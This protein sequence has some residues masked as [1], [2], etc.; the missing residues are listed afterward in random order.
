MNVLSAVATDAAIAVEVK[1][2]AAGSVY[3]V[4]ATLPAGYH[5]PAGKDVHLLI[6]TDM[7]DKPVIRIPVSVSAEPPPVLDPW[8]ARPRAM[9][10]RPAPAVTLKTA[11][12]CEIRLGDA[13][14][15]PEKAT[16]ADGP[17]APAVQSPQPPASGLSLQRD[18][19]GQSP[20]RP[21]SGPTRQAPRDRL[22]AVMFWTGR[23]GHCVR[24]LPVFQR[25]AESYADR[26]VEFVT[27]CA[28]DRNAAQVADA[29]GQRGLRLPV[30]LDP[31][32]TAARRYAIRAFP[33]VCLIGKDG[34]IESVHGRRPT[35][36][37]KDGLENL[38]GDLRSQLD[39]LLALD[40]PGGRTPLTEPGGPASPASQGPAGKARGRASR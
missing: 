1:E 2:H 25:V 15:T 18:S 11:D 33:F 3:V 35:Y 21:G 26:A 6:T 13:A 23:C 37:D 19:V 20:R 9:V 40:T 16:G 14:S 24:Q 7:T 30:G 22:T 31:D 12:G 34:R 39:R 28:G 32:Y 27:V 29:A 36:D 8:M 4:T 10:G 38:E 17:S 5:T